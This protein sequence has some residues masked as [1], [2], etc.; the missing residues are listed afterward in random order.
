MDKS[1]TT[2]MDKSMKSN[3]E[4]VR[5]FH[6]AFNK[7]PD[8]SFPKLPEKNMA[9]LRAKLIKEEFLEVME[10]LGITLNRSMDL[11]Y[12]DDKE[13]D[14]TKIAKELSDLLYVVY[15]TAAA[16]G[17]PIDDVY[18]EVHRSNMSKLGIDGKPIYREDGKVL[19]GP[20]YSPADI[21]KIMRV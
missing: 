17:I 4:L 7:A 12:I 1:S 15:G 16:Y 19:K 13:K 2:R 18:R 8:P 21:S 11:E 14:L 10:E 5:D 20:N 6:F 9:I 3:F